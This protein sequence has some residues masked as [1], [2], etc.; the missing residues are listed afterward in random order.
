MTIETEIDNPPRLP[1]QLKHWLNRAGIYGY[2]K[3]DISRYNFFYGASR[4][5]A[6]TTGCR[7]QR[8]HFRILPHLDRMDI[9][10][11]YMDRWANSMGASVSPIPRT[12]GEFKAAIATLL[13]KARGRV[14]ETHA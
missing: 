11:G 1:K 2:D 9:C 7:E 12:E 10:D 6:H 13:K 14:R 3:R 8:R 5:K 4:K